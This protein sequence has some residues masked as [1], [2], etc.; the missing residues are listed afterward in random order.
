MAVLGL[1]CCTGFPLVVGSGGYS[2]V[3]VRSLPSQWL[4]LLWSSGSRMHGLLE[5]W[6]RG[7]VAPQHVRFS[8]IRDQTHVSCIGRRLLYHCATREASLFDFLIFLLLFDMFCFNII[9]NVSCLLS[10]FSCVL[11]FAIL[12]TAC[13]QAPLS[14]KFFQARILEWMPCRDRTHV[15]LCFLGWQVGSF[16]YNVYVVQNTNSVF[17]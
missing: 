9:Y 15:S 13:C 4:L 2:L 17:S 10:G 14:M 11:L 3:A 1:H 8:W 16:Q 5:L 7:L 12:W 6:H